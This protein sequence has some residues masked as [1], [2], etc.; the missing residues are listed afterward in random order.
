MV[1][2]EIVVYDGD[3]PFCRLAAT[4][5]SLLLGLEKLD[6]DSSDAQRL[7]E[8]EFED[9]GFTLYLF[10][11]DTVYFGGE[12]SRRV[13]ERVGLPQFLAELVS[14]HYLQLAGLLSVLTGRRR[15]VELPSC[16]GECRVHRGGGSKPRS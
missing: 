4:T 5:A 15:S 3:C 1:M 2:D 12:A 6:F 10:E 11:E 8:D 9:P 14:R 7:L 13:A 16:N